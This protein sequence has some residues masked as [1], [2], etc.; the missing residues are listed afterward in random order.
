MRGSSCPA[1]AAFAT[2]SRKPRFCN[3]V[4]VALAHG[5]IRMESDFR[6][7]APTSRAGAVGIGQIKPATA[8]S[9]GVSGIQPSLRNLE[10]SMRYLRLALDWAAADAAGSVFTSAEFSRDRPAPATAARSCASQASEG[11]M[12]WPHESSIDELND[13]SPGPT[14]I[15]WSIWTRRRSW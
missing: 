11:E 14:P 13:G 1:S 5:V 12:N 15:I 7:R 3:G 2:W 6:C 4:P 8:R 10:A 9:V